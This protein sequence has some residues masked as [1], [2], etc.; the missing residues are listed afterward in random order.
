MK[1]PECGNEEVFLVAI[2]A[3]AMYDAKNDILYNYGDIKIDDR[4]LITCCKCNHIGRMDEF[5]TKG[6]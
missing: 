4:E 6:K 2:S 3:T 1:C 5:E